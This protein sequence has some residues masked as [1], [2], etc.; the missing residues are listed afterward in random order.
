MGFGQ[1]RPVRTGADVG[2]DRTAVADGLDCIAVADGLAGCNPG[3][4]LLEDMRPAVSH[5]G[6][7]ADEGAG[8]GS[9][10]RVG[11]R[12]DRSR[13][14]AAVVAVVHSLVEYYGRCN[15]ADL[16]VG[17]HRNDDLEVRESRNHCR[18]AEGHIG[19]EVGR[20]I[21][22]HVDLGSNL[23]V[24]Y[25]RSSVLRHLRRSNLLLTWWDG[26]PGCANRRAVR[27]MCSDF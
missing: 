23:V 18:P 22:H 2:L 10:G 14:R 26:C 6:H 1:Q 4:D 8:S 19:S 12:V 9:H 13:R 24:G 15:L 21:V 27:S 17:R 3:N 16:E 7:I 25:N 5:P 20:V 11:H